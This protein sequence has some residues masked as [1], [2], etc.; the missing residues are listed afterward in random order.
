ML[1]IGVEASEAPDDLKGSQPNAK[2]PVSPEPPPRKP[3]QLIVKQL[4]Y[5]ND[6]LEG[7][8]TL[9]ERLSLRYSLRTSLVREQNINLTLIREAADLLGH[10]EIQQWARTRFLIE[11]ELDKW[12]DDRNIGLD[13]YNVLWF[14][15]NYLTYNERVVDGSQ[16]RSLATYKG[17]KTVVDWYYWASSYS[18]SVD[19]ARIQNLLA[20]FLCQDLGQLKLS[21]LQFVGITQDNKGRI[22]YAFGLPNGAAQV[23]SLRELH[24]ERHQPDLENRFKLANA[25]VRTI[26]GMHSLGWF[27]GN[28]STLNVVFSPQIEGVATNLSHPYLLGF[29]LQG[30]N[31]NKKERYGMI[32]EYP[33]GMAE[34]TG[35]SKYSGGVIE[36]DTIEYSVGDSDSG[37][38]RHPE[39]RGTNR[40]SPSGWGTSTD[41]FKP[42]Y[43]IYSLGVVLWEIGIWKALT[44]RWRWH[45]YTSSGWRTTTSKGKGSHETLT[46]EAI[47]ELGGQMGRRYTNAVIAC[48]DG[49]FDKIWEPGLARNSQ[50]LYDHLREFQEKII[51][52]LAACSV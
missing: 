44:E 35:I 16:L 31:K 38:Y 5:Y 32:I 2:V 17:R 9:L 21:I 40:A 24:V 10:V 29:G 47:T 13:E 7:H 20:K 50:Q 1:F 42:S 49:T 45:L 8:S 37:Y 39:F 33:G 48:L 14:D 43:D 34:S 19:D 15:E 18:I 51:D 36:S 6:C 26:F 4:C 23:E 28:V 12:D 30:F 27:H 52:P 3:L 11:R 22:G 25:L 41:T 46:A